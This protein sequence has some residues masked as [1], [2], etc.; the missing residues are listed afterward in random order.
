MKLTA[1]FPG[2]YIQ[3]DGALGMLAEEIRQ[4]GASALVVAGG[5]AER[6]VLPVHLPEWQGCNRRSAIGRVET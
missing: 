5:T 6:A 4:L 1:I 3:A 2:R